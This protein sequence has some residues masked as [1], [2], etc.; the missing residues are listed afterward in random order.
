MS[1]APTQNLDD[2]PVQVIP[3][4]P[5]TKAEEVTANIIRMMLKF[6]VARVQ[7]ETPDLVDLSD[8]DRKALRTEAI[9]TRRDGFKAQTAAFASGIEA[10]YDDEFLRREGV[11]I[12]YFLARNAKNQ[13]RLIEEET[14]SLAVNKALYNIDDTRITIDLEL[15]AA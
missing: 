6:E 4:Q 14:I 11:R 8:D 2:N 12:A 7:L 15:L 10:N 5:E 1:L 3:F 9:K 13:A